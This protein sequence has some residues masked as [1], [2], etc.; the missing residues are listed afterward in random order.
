MRFVNIIKIM[1]SLEIRKTELCKASYHWMLEDENQIKT[2]IGW[3]WRSIDVI[4][5]Y[6]PRYNEG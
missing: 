2:G 5:E 6:W 3:Y 4:R 1:P